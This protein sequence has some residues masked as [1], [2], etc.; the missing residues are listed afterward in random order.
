MEQ[1]YWL[2]LSLGVILVI[3]EMIVPGIFLL[4]IGF[5]AVIVSLLTFLVPMAPLT[6]LTLF[7]GFSIFLSWL[8]QFIWVRLAPHA[9]EEPL[10]R[11]GDALLGTEHVLNHPIENGQAQIKI[12]DSV[13]LVRGPDMPQGT[14]VKIIKIDGTILVVESV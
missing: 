13:W 11:R 1:I 5:A 8:G 2:W 7:A 4:W 12:G 6:Q 14:K 3:L 9:L 10:N